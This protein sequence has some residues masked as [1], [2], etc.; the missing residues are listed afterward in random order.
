VHTAVG[1]TGP[2]RFD[3]VAF[4]RL[5]EARQAQARLL[6]SPALAKHRLVAPV[7]EIWRRHRGAEPVGEGGPGP[8]VCCLHPVGRFDVGVSRW[9]AHEE[10]LLDQLLEGVS[11]ASLEALG[12]SQGVARLHAWIEAGWL[13]G[14]AAD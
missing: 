11:L 2:E 7:D 12:S 14:F 3:W 6:P 5:P 9:N 1:R 13:V 8:Y 4:G 10:A